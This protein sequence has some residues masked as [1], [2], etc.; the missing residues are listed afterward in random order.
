MRRLILSLLLA[1]ALPACR[2]AAVEPPVPTP[3]EEITTLL[4]P[5]LFG[6]EPVKIAERSWSTITIM[7]WPHPEVLW[8]G[9]GGNPVA[10]RP[11]SSRPPEFRR[12]NL[13]GA[14]MLLPSPAARE[15][16]VDHF[17]RDEE[18]G[19]TVELPTPRAYEVGDGATKV[20][21][22]SG[23]GAGTILRIYDLVSSPGMRVAI[24]LV[25]SGGKTMIG[26]YELAQSDSSAPHVAEVPLVDLPANEPVTLELTPSVASARLWALIFEADQQT[27]D[28]R[29]HSSPFSGSS[30]AH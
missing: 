27:G 4:L 3:P 5:V 30:T 18:S 9:I 10:V 25:Q 7:E 8:V 15:L 13:S 24:T 17:L 14:L 29:V 26:E 6:D 2:E 19:T 23:E 16:R 21:W 1:I 22:T 12:N 20:T 28:I 11:G